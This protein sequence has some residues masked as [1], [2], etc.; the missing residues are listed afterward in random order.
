M[1]SVAV[2][3]HT[4][5]T[6][7]GG[8][9]ELREV[10]AGEGVADPIWYEVPKSKKAPKCARRAVDDGADLVFVWGGDGTVQRSIDALA[11]TEATIAIIPA[12]TAN[13]L[14]TNLGIP[15]DIGAAV[16]IG[17]HGARRELDV[18]VVNGERFAVMAGAGFDARMIREADSGM[19]DRVGR[20]A[21]VF[22]GAKNLRGG[23]VRTRIW[24]DGSKWFDDLAACVLV[25][26]VGTILGGI[27]AFEHA[28]PDDGRLELG[29]VTADGVMQ[30]LRALSRTALGKAEKSPF[31]QTTSAQRI[32]V[33]MDEATPYELDGGARKKA[34]RLKIRVEPAAI[35]VCVPEDGD[36]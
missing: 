9:G 36:E 27:D 25:G 16:H 28:R 32:N 20:L 18:G 30:W 1:T 23:R 12:G 31:V 26:N 10:L 29:V 14:A 2:I 13:L 6:L 24:I 7:G 11:D 21:Y 3:A 8:L 35:T 33:R 5:K 17:L 19:K 22:T 15:K 34:K 4:R